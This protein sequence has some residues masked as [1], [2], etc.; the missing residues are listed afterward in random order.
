MAGFYMYFAITKRDFT[1]G[2][3]RERIIAVSQRHH[4]VPLTYN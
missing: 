3:W 4:Q 2:S 1:L